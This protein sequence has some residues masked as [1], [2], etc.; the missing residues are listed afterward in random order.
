MMNVTFPLQTRHNAS[1]PD[2]EQYHVLPWVC[3]LVDSTT[4]LPSTHLRWHRLGEVASG[5][6]VD[7]VNNNHGS[8][9]AGILGK[10]VCTNDVYPVVQRITKI[11]SCVVR[12]CF[13]AHI[14]NGTSIIFVPSN[15]TYHTTEEFKAEDYPTWT[16]C[17]VLGERTHSGV[18]A[19][20]NNSGRFRAYLVTNDGQPI[21][22][23]SPL[24]PR[25]LAHLIA[26]PSRAAFSGVTFARI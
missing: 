25:P 21:P 6:R 9:Y 8:C 3:R 17:N 15:P 2:G 16:A 11:L 18:P 14:F 5:G 13:C 19:R 12:V 24:A 20:K 7:D 23:W 1:V 10:R 4:G 22:S 26:S